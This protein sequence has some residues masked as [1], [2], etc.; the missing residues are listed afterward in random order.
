MRK[1]QMMKLAI[2]D[3]PL[4]NIDE[5]NSNDICL[6]NNNCVFKLN[7]RDDSSLLKGFHCPCYNEF[8]YKCGKSFCAASKSVC[9]SFSQF[10]NNKTEPLKHINKCLN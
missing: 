10:I 4:Q 2:R 3:C 5:F 8:S 9:D 1:I 7:T 6:N